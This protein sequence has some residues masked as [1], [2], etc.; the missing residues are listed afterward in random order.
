MIGV[1]VAAHGDLAQALVS[2][3]Q[4]V[5]RQ[6]GRVMAVSVNA[7][8]DSASYEKRLRA[9][10]LEVMGDRGVLVLTDMFGGTP[11]N[12]GLTMHQSG[13]VE[14][15]TGANLPMLIKAMQLAGSPVDLATAA[16]DVRESGARA[17]AIASEMLSV[18][19]VI[20][21]EKQA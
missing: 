8:D 10:V 4:Q 17:I 18:P 1:V 16:R 19:R 2:T 6:P 5:I 9:A 21:K 15:L 13:E 12:V 11:S 20:L 7:Q 3:A 14:V